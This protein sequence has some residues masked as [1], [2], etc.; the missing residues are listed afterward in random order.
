MKLT[1]APPL[2]VE[3]KAISI[4]QYEALTS[5]IE[6]AKQGAVDAFPYSHPAGEKAARRAEA[7]RRND[8]AAELTEALA[9]KT[10]AQVVDALLDGTLHPA[11]TID[12]AKA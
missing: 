10:R 1:A 4:T 8:L 3:P 2:A 5:D 12:W 9:N 7:N 11:I 6:I